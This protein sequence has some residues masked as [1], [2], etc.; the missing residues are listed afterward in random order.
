MALC[1]Y[2]RN[3]TTG[4]YTVCLWL[5]VHTYVIILQVYILCAY[6]SMYISDWC[7][8]RNAFLHTYVCLPNSDL[9]GLVVVE[10]GAV[11]VGNNRHTCDHSMEYLAHVLH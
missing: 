5:Y 1:T 11:V 9:N 2:I 3:N 7:S 10:A 8:S 6:G 4:I